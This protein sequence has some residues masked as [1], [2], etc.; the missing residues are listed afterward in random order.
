MT[1]VSRL[2]GSFDLVNTYDTG[3]VSVGFIQFI[4]SDD[5]RHSLATVLLREKEG[6]PDS[7]RD[8]FHRFGV[9]VTTDGILTVLDPATGVELAG[10]DA[11][12]KIIDDKQLIAVFQRAGRVSSAFRIAQIKIAKEIYWPENDPVTVTISGVALTGKVSDVVRSEAWMATLFDRKVNRGSIAPLPDVLTRVMTTHRLKRLS[13]AAAYEAEIVAGCRY[14][15]D[16]LSDKTLQ[17]PPAAP[18]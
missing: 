3:F 13:D 7:F 8:D 5:G 10:P 6:A 16:F 2:E 14:R 18:H 4:T 9:D 12:R 1:A 11:V 17:Q 15:F